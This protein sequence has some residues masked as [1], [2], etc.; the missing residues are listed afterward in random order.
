MV[1]LPNKLMEQ[2]CDPAIFS[3][4]I[5]DLDFISFSKFSEG[6]QDCSSRR[7]TDPLRGGSRIKVCGIAGRVWQGVSGVSSRGEQGVSGRAYRACLA[8]VEQGVSS[9]G[10]KWQWNSVRFL[11][12]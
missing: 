6:S 12:E 3:E 5:S 10:R 11:V 4:V 2:T 1:K 8:G 9:R 7:W